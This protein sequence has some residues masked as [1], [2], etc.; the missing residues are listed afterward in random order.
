[1]AVKQNA[2]HVSKRAEDGK[3]QVKIGGSDKVI[4]L[5]NTKAEAEAWTAQTAQNTGRGVLVH[6]SKGKNKGKIQ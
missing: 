4:K 2:Y 5:F 6:A 1:M 3:W